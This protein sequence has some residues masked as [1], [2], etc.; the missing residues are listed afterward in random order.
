MTKPLHLTRCPEEGEAGWVLSQVGYMLACSL[1]APSFRFL[2]PVRAC[3][4]FFDVQNREVL[5]GLSFCG[6]NYLNL[7]HLS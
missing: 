6:T 4:Q 7:Q 5:F 3:A 2:S 1:E